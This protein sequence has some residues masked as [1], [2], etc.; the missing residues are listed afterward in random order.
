MKIRRRLALFGALALALTLVGSVTAVTAT[1][2]KAP[3][4]KG[5]IS[6]DGSSTVG[7]WTIAAAEM[8]RKAQ[9]KV[10]VTV[11]ISGTGGGFERFCRGE[12]DLSNASRPIK[13]SEY[14]NCQKNGIKWVAFTV[15][16]DGIT[17]ATSKQNTWAT[18]LTTAELKK[19]WNT[20]SKVDNWKD[21]RPG[22]PD[23][24]LK[25]FGPG[26][27]S[28][29]FDFF[30]EFI[31]GKQK[32]S[33]S[34]YTASEDDNI[35]VQGV[36]G[37][38]G[39]LGYFGLSY[40]E[41]NTNKL[42]DVAVDGGGGCVKPNKKTVQDRTYKPLSRGLYIYAK[43]DSFKRAEVR[44]FIGF[45]LNNQ[46]KVAKAARFVALTPAQAKRSRFHYKAVLRQV[47]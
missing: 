34:D 14:A 41:E 15:A 11:G 5:S 37:T 4:L 23:V 12:I 8:Y 32:A 33:R 40:Y 7:P 13:S 16:N 36:S 21:I 45:A 25:L 20:G 35:L 38:R 44:S 42:N 6:A 10:K 17:I 31:N 30:T 46:V 19:I 24:P 2:K 29:T 22:F 9:P 39:G 18:C 47:K 1:A 3:Q 27:D 28:G 26:T 43:R